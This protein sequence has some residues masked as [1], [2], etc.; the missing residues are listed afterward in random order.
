M[1]RGKS[2]YK[3]INR[4]VLNREHEC[5]FFFFN[6]CSSGLSVSSVC[7]SL[8]SC[9][10][11]LSC[12]SVCLQ[13]SSRK[14]ITGPLKGKKK[15]IIKVVGY[16]TTECARSHLLL[17]LCCLCVLTDTICC[18]FVFP[19]RNDVGEYDIFTAEKT[20]TYLIYGE[21]KCTEHTEDFIVLKQSWKGESAQVIQSKKHRYSDARIVEEVKVM[22]ESRVY[23]LF[24]IDTPECSSEFRVYEL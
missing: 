4:I 21:V 9:V 24:N 6:L 5:D 22:Q 11:F 23:L 18:C 14:I 12:L 15:K 19:D 17:L 2:F 20:A 3:R 16:S 1:P 8:T 13:V 7:P 10:Y